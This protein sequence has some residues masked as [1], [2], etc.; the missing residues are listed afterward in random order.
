MADGFN[1]EKWANIARQIKELPEEEAVALMAQLSDDEL[2][3]LE[4]A[5]SITSDL[6]QAKQALLS[7]P[8]RA[9]D[10]AGG[11]A[12]T[13]LAA[14]ADPLVE[15]NLVTQEDLLNALKGQ[16][17]QS[18]EFLERGGVPEMG[19]VNVPFVGPV[20]GRDVLGFGLD[21]ATDPL[22][23]AT[24][25]GG[26]ARKAA[27]KAG[28]TTPL[29]SARSVLAPTETLRQKAGR[30]LY[31]ASASLK[32]GDIAGAKVGKGDTAVS[33]VLF[34]YG[35]TGG[36]KETADKA[37]DLAEQLYQRQQQILMDASE[38]GAQVDIEKALLR[39]AKKAK[40]VATGTQRGAVLPVRQQA[41]QAGAVLEDLAAQQAGMYGP[42]NLF[43]PVE[44][45]RAKTQFYGLLGDDAYSQLAKS[46]E[47]ARI[48]KDA[49][50]RT[51]TAVEAGIRKVD[52]QLARELREVN[53]DLGALLSSKKVMS[54][55]A[56]K[57]IMKNSITPVD[58][59][60]L[61]A[62]PGTAAAKKAGDI[63]KAP[64]FRTKAG[65]SLATDPGVTDVLLRRYL[66]DT[67][68]EEQ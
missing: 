14:A 28:K 19:S 25:G 11:V 56:G 45:S 8:G 50:S 12:R 7:V 32:R 34:K 5:Q 57:E 63:L 27:V 22:T 20:S 26:A 9:A 51:K 2:S 16:A 67:Q 64:G 58:T 1:P 40:Q 59:A 54:T 6:E 48:F 4:R 52:P 35:I 3:Q 61:F 66:L 36:A 21:V 44:A 33:N 29:L 43:T 42:G 41:G 60:L 47:G 24:L 17:P 53:R 31:G 18:A 49:A 39:P 38:M 10:Y 62:S 55:E 68:G 30:A 15:A 65:M 23:Y 13:G 46:D 37:L